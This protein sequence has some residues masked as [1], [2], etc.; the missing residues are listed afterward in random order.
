MQSRPRLFLM[1]GAL[2]LSQGIPLGLAMEALPTLLR[3]DG[4]ALQALAWLPLVGLPWVLKF[5]W[6]SQVDNRW[7]PAWGRRRSWILP[8]QLLALGCLLILAMVGTDDAALGILLL[9]LASLASAT[10]DIATDGLTAEHF[11]SDDLARANA[12]QVGGTMVGFFLGG[13]GC[14]TLG[15]YVGS[16]GAVLGLAGLVGFSLLMVSLW[17]EP[18]VKLARQDR[19]CLRGFL[20]RPGAW[21]LVWAAGLSAMAV[22]APYGLAKLMLVDA[23]WAPEAIGRLGL[24]GGAVTLL[25]GC[26]GG[27]WLAERIGPRNA[28]GLGLLASAAAATAW[29][30][31][32][33][34]E[35][36][37][38]GAFLAQA[39]ASF[40]AGAASVGLMTLAMRFAQDGRQA[41]TD[42]TAVQSARDLG[43]VMASAGMTALAA[44]LGYS[45]SFGVSLG[46]ALLVLILLLLTFTPGR[47]KPVA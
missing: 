47:A 10:Q 3:R 34:G 27:A 12:I 21:P 24:A 15:A 37:P 22:A 32:A 20:R 17:R 14:L 43:E 31:L 5:L 46:G 11:S 13:P 36:G 40:G 39:L 29:I 44:Q 16:R 41:G 45:V 18:P 38:L 8:M 25:L 6:A 28:L 33:A 1:I 4:A 9:G 30:A 23:G 42:M 26:G 2:Y 7:S 35:P 19:A